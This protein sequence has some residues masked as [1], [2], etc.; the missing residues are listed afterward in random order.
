MILIGCRDAPYDALHCGSAGSWGRYL[1]VVGGC[2]AWGALD[3]WCLQGLEKGFLCRLHSYSDYFSFCVAV[4]AFSKIV[5]RETSIY[6]YEYVSIE[7]SC[8][9][10]Q[11]ACRPVNVST[12]FQDSLN[13]PATY[14]PSIPFPYSSCAY[15]Y[16]LTRT[17]YLPFV[18]PV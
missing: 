7:Q 13:I 6:D 18:V 10:G 8:W 16:R 14:R 1:F 4:L 3:L 17:L 2:A 11:S 9:C 12:A 15:S 5:S